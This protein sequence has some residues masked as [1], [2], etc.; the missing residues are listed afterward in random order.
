MEYT[1][2][3]SAAAEHSRWLPR[4]DSVDGSLVVNLCSN[5]LAETI[6]RKGCNSKPLRTLWDAGADSQ[7]GT[8]DR[9]AARLDQVTLAHL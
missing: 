9:T 4:V 8:V 5:H 3:P 6:H 7:S 2:V 1:P